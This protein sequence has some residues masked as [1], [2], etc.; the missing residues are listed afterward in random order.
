MVLLGQ[1][2]TVFRL[3]FEFKSLISDSK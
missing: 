1:V 3:N 2:S